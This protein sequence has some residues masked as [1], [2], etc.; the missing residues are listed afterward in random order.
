MAGNT[1]RRG[2]SRRGEVDLAVDVAHAADKVAVGGGNAALAGGED[3][4]IAAEARPACGR[5]DDAARV[6]EDVRIAA[7]HA[8]AVDALRRGDDD[9]AH[10]GGEV[11]TLQDG[12][13]GAKVQLVA[14]KSITRSEG[15]AVRVIDKRNLY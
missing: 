1:R 7:V 14:P 11:V 5:G 3:A 8:L 2:D 15:K 10:A 13:G 12:R 4:H 9:P 6:E